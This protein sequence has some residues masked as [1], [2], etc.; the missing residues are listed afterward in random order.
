MSGHRIK[1]QFSPLH[2]SSQ[3]D[4]IIIGITPKDVCLAVKIACCS[5]GATHTFK[6]FWI[7]ISSLPWYN[8]R[9]QREK[10][11]LQILCYPVRINVLPLQSFREDSHESPQTGLLF[12]L[13]AADPRLFFFWLDH[14]LSLG[15]SSVD[16]NIIRH[17]EAM[18]MEIEDCCWPG[19][20]HKLLYKRRLW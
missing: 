1:S 5:A 9:E 10:H 4:M 6:R 19:L 18:K 16:D 15:L 7:M 13:K 14:I 12:P 8:W 3:A 2:Y 17:A 20:C 11:S